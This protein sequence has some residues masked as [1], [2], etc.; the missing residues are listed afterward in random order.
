MRH[1]AAPTG[2]GDPPSYSA[3]IV[4]AQKKNERNALSDFGLAGVCLRLLSVFTLAQKVTSISCF[5]CLLVF[6]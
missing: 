1:Y 2:K 4:A 5:C 6:I 3:L